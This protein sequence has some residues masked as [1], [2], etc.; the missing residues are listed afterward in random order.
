MVVLL[1]SKSSFIRLPAQ[2]R[3]DAN[4]LRRNSTA[5]DNETYKV[6]KEI[7]IRSVLIGNMMEGKSIARIRLLYDERIKALIRP[8]SP[9]LI[10]DRPSIPTIYYSH[11]CLSCLHVGNPLSPIDIG[12]VNA[13][14]PLPNVTSNVLK[15]VSPRNP[16]PNLL[17]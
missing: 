7:A 3:S 10:L 12:D 8:M 1:T 4:Q 16:L 2:T 14:I 5:S 13:P 9:F 17:P 15:K 6:E 11:L